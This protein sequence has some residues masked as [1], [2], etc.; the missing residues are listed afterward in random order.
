MVTVGG[1]G[2]RLGVVGCI[3]VVAALAAVGCTGSNATP[4]IIYITLP[5]S[6][7]TPLPSGVT[8]APTVALPLPVIDSVLI[9]SNAPD[10]RWTVTFKKPV[11]SGISTGAATKMNDTIA[12]LVNGYISTFTGSGLPAVA[13][14]M[15]PSTLEGDFSIALDSPTLLSLRFTMLSHTSGAAHPVGQPGSASF[16]VSSGAAIKLTDI[17]NNPATATAILATQAH[18]ALAKTLGPD[19]TWDGTAS[20]IAFFDKAWAMTPAG[21]EFTWGQ[22]DIASQAAGMP[23]AT[24]AWSGVKAIIKSGSPAAEFVQ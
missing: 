16:V 10:N 1:R 22:G 17:L 19:L 2:A 5:P 8:P 23:S 21:L 4:P 9:S 6:S 12:N 7:P 14:G 11:V 3:S 20:S 24:L 13:I 15:G 18:T